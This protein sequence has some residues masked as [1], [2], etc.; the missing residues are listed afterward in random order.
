L[1]D[2]PRSTRVLEIG[3]PPYGMT[4]LMRQWMFDDITVTGYDEKSEDQ[5]RAISECPVNIRSD[6]GEVLFDGIEHRFN[7][8]IHRWP[9]ADEQFDLIVSC[10]TFEHLVLD[11][12]HAYAEANRVLKTGGRLFVTVPNGLALSNGLRYLH[13]EQPNSFAFYRPEG[14]NLRHHREPTPRELSALLKAAGFEPEFVKTFNIAR[15]AVDSENPL[16]LLALGFTARPLE[17]RREL[18]TARGIKRTPVIER[19][20][21]AEGLYYEWDL[22]RLRKKSAAQAVS[23]AIG[24]S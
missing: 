23:S 7:V 3:A 6:G 15:P 12:M 9:F 11:P 19:Y 17:L 10:E 13:G 14:F 2:L 20:P 21:T 1:A 16:N 4:L 22:T 24:K 18:L 8:E 5:L